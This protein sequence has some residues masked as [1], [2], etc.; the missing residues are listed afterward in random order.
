MQ[1][2]QISR[3]KGRR[4]LESCVADS[5]SHNALIVCRGQRSVWGSA[6]CT[7]LLAGAK[8]VPAFVFLSLWFVFG[9]LAGHSTVNACNRCYAS[10]GVL[11]CDFDGS[12]QCD[13]L[14]LDLMYKQGDLVAGVPVGS[15]NPFD[16]D[17][18]LVID[19]TDLTIWLT[20]AAAENGYP[21]PYLRG[22]T[23]DLLGPGR[24]PDIDIT[25]FNNSSANF[26]PSGVNAHN[27]TWA[28]GNVDGDN[29]IDITD[30]NF[31]S[32]N[33]APQGYTN[34]PEPSSFSLV[35]LGFVGIVLSL[36]PRQS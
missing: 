34:L 1:R 36:L 31:L 8:N 14:D 11:P 6:R 4:D 18:N 12:R 9:L 20:D 28:R 7:T 13:M 23:D 25:D 27:N 3:G 15:G 35:T 32:A 2:Q 26:D 30:F 17:A 24:R 29:D 21:F 16:L 22:D 33:F 19:N 5:R 10:M